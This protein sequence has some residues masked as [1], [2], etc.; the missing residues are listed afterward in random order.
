M[1]RAELF[2]P[3]VEKTLV[4]T[5][6]EEALSKLADNVI[7]IRA[8]SSLVVIRMMEA[9]EPRLQVFSTVLHDVPISPELLA[10][11][12]ELNA[13]IAFAKAFWIEDDVLVATELLAE[14]LDTENIRNAVTAIGVASD[15]FDDELRA[16]FGGTPSFPDEG[17]AQTE[18]P[19]EHQDGVGEGVGLPPGDENGTTP[20]AAASPDSKG[21][22]K[23]SDESG[24]RK[25]DDEEP[26]QGYL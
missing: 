8:G 15:H 6:G 3:Y 20:T 25:K 10:A 11:L 22:S 17:E 7:T 9:T 2:W 12:N 24:D 13:K 14:G 23:E 21:K 19:D 26:T 4:E 18:A 16:Q 5:F 1:A